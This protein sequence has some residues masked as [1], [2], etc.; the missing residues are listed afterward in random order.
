MIFPVKR[1]ADLGFEILATEGTA[2]VLHRHGVVATVVRKH[3]EA[4]PTGPPTRSQR[5]LAGEIDL[6]VNTPYG[7]GPAARRLRDPDRRRGQGRAV[8]TTVQGLA[9]A[10]Q[11]IEALV[12]GADRRASAAGVRCGREPRRWTSRPW[13]RGR[14][15][16]EPVQVAARSSPPGGSATTTRSRSWRPASPSGTR[17][18]H[19]VALAVGGGTPAMLLRRAFSIYRV[20]ERG[21]YGGTVEIVFAVH[22][23]G[24]AW[25]AERQPHDPVDV[26][27]PLGRAVRAAARAGDGDARRRRLRHARRCSP[28]P[29]SCARAAA[30][31]TSCSAPRPRTGC[32][33]RSRPSACRPRSRS[34]PRTA[35]WGS[36]DG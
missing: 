28:S 25:L 7:V 12:S 35:R 20:Q 34:P 9:A 16:G 21:V 27:G 22:G 11:G 8:I 26:V 1:L 24:T 6:I 33:G 14:A 2:E 18:G 23:K 32:S 31:S 5:I 19:F 30:G 29:S 10:V 36:A 13:T 3:R 4:E 15:D 17:P